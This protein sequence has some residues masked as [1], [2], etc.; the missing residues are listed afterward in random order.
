MATDLKDLKKLVRF[1]RREGIVALKMDGI[2]FAL[3]ERAPQALKPRGKSAVKE[4]DQDK[5][6]VEGRWSEEDLLEWSS[7]SPM[8]PI[9]QDEA[10]Q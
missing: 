6:K 7:S 4:K 5:I 10:E 1:C 3:S 9:L 8:D 2:E